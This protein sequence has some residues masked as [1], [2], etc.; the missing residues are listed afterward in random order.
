[1][2]VRDADDEDGAGLAREAAL[3]AADLCDAAWAPEDPGPSGTEAP[4][5]S[6]RSDADGL[7]E[8]AA[9]ALRRPEPP[10]RRPAWPA[11]R[12]VALMAA[13]VVL[14]GFGLWL[15]FS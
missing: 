14:V 6:L 10:G 9:R 1:M 7:V 12:A 13:A 11:V 4:A 5:G 2:A 8:G 3:A 15:V